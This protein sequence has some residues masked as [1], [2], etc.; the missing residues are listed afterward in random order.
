MAYRRKRKTGYR[1]KRKT[2]RRYKSKRY[3]GKRAISRTMPYSE[4]VPDR[5]FVKLRY[6]DIFTHTTNAIPNIMTVVATYQSSLHDSN[7]AIG[8]HQP[9]WF[10]QYAY[11]YSS[12]RVY[13][14]KYSITA[15]VENKNE[16]CTFGV[17]QLNNPAVVDTT[18]VAWMERTDAKV[19]TIGSVNGMNQAY[20]KG[21][22]SVAKTRGISKYTLRSDNNFEAIWSANPALMGYIG[23]YDQSTAASAIITYTIKLIYYAELFDKVTPGTS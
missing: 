7:Y 19:K 2:Y 20:I 11:F 17:R 22:M 13:G 4:P 21:Y 12:Y 8:G 16:A 3:Y 1:R 15:N 6:A 14:I 23:I 9:L 10:D 5:L 18:I